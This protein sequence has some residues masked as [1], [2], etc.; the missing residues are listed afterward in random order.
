MF[1]AIAAALCIS[2]A[3]TG[4]A[5]EGE[6]I[7]E[8]HTWPRGETARIEMRLD[9]VDEVRF[10]VNGWLPQTV[11][12]MDGTAT[13]AI[14]TRL[15]RTG[16][17]DVRAQLV[18]KGAVMKTLR[19]PFTVGKPHDTERMPVW[20]WGG[21][22]SN[23]ELLIQCGFT[24]GWL[25]SLHDPE[26][27]RSP[28]DPDRFRTYARRLEEAARNDFDLGL[29]L[30]PLI[31]KKLAALPGACGRLPDGAPAERP[32][33][34]S[35]PAMAHARALARAAMERFAQFP[36]LRHVMMCSEYQTPMVLHDRAIELAKEEIGL[37]I[38]TLPFTQGYRN[39]GGLKTVRAGAFPDGI[40]PDDH[41]HYLF[42]KWWWERGHGTAAL[43]AAM[44]EIVKAAR[45]DVI[46]WHEPYRLAPVRKS[47][48]RLDMIGTW[49]YGWPDI[50]RLV[51]TTYLQAA[52]RPEHQKVQ[53]DITL[54]VYG[55]MA[56]PLK[57]STAVFDHDYA[58]RDPYF[59]AG[60]D[61]AREATWIVFSQR[62][63]VL[64]YYSAGALN[65]A[66][67]D[68]DP[69]VTSPETFYAIGEL[70]R[71][72]IR[73]FGPAVLDCARVS[74]RVAVLASAAAAWFPAR[75]IPGYRN[76][77][78]LAYATLLMRNHVPFDVLLDDDIVEGAAERY[79]VLV[80]PVADTLT[81]N[82]VA[83]IRD[84]IE[85]GGRVIA[86][87]PWRIS[88]PGVI[89]TDYDFR[90]QRYISGREY[91]KLVTPDEDDAK[92]SEYAADL[93]RHLSG[94]PR[95]AAAETQKVL[96]NSLESGDVAYHFF[97]NDLR[98][99][100][101]RFGK[102]KIRQELGV[103]QKA[104]VS[105]AVGDRP[106]LYDALMR[107][108]IDYESTDGR[109]RFQLT[110]PAAQGKVIVALREPIGGVAVETVG[111]LMLG[112]DVT[113]RIRVLGESGA[114]IAG[115]LPLRVEITDPLGRVSEWSRFTTTRRGKDG[116]CEFTFTPALND[117]PGEWTVTV[118]DW[119][120]GKQAIVPLDVAAS[121]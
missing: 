31:S 108:R 48:T 60:P 85:K 54:F 96:T 30:H 74:P 35:E 14:D 46:T 73:P 29:Y 106:V 120:A 98:T 70:S 45:P 63:D 36:A 6:F 10:D 61:Y 26:G 67:T 111:D 50:K 105:V 86:N 100:G 104:R 118:T 112:R 27:G 42:L 77:Q 87:K 1:R 12:A 110:L 84:F 91:E 93:A 113:L 119:V 114:A 66:R 5:T 41:P 81:R 7:T 97:I 59:T 92:M 51:Y 17:Y 83:K 115:S 9:E 52:A 79:D 18:S 39:R 117:V 25:S 99:Y 90:H 24:G 13:F 23:Q 38:T 34:L 107:R 43:N 76:E 65:F 44:H 80:M 58:G 75:S 3:A 71:C 47:H 28:N 20:K 102:Y 78:T 88:L 57:E 32:Y 8:V 95:P 101:P 68:L 40:I 11:P 2:F 82:M 121:D 94:V 4:W 21:G 49:T 72:L 55:H 15:L 56:V 16:D 53:Q 69:T 89:V 62:P 37:D 103:T 33:P 64:A 109:A 116:V 19:F 22:G